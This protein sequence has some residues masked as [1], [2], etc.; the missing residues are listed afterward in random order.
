MDLKRIRFAVLIVLCSVIL[1][2]FGGGVIISAAAEAEPLEEWDISATA[3]VDSVVAKLYKISNQEN[4]YSLI[5]EGDGRMKDF[6][7]A[8][9]PPWFKSYKDSLAFATVGSGITYIGAYAFFG[10]TEFESLTV[11]NP[12]VSFYIMEDTVL[13]S[14]SAICAHENSTAKSY[15]ELIYFKRFVRICDFED[16]ECVDCGYI[17]A[18]HIGG[19]ATCER[20]AQCEICGVEY[21]SKEE[22]RYSEWIDGVL[23]GCESYGVFG[24]YEC[25]KCS[26]FFDEDYNERQWIYISPL[27]HNYGDLIPAVAADCTSSGSIDHYECAKCG[28]HFDSLK[29]KVD[30]IFTAA[31]G[32]TGGTPSCC[33]PAICERCG[34]EYGNIATGNH[35]FP[36]SLSYD[37]DNHWYECPCGERKD[38]SAHSYKT[39][40][41]KEPSETEEG[42][43]RRYCDCGYKM[44]ESIDKLKPNDEDDPPKSEKTSFPVGIAIVITSVV[45]IAA[46][47]TAVIIKKIRRS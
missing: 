8:S 17:C 13:P 43:K 40:V 33:G 3:G 15:A 37:S 25:L 20:L 44:V 30:F 39:E 36:N 35:D 14:Y 28:S 11:Y 45:V 6:S 41:I 18:S 5:I 7:S 38:S 2:L 10:C 29:N 46:T 34:R 27:G 12:F 26:K 47:F 22:H 9:L 24:H 1:V 16:S 32:H 19:E 21:G 31:L 4:I 23:P 42:L